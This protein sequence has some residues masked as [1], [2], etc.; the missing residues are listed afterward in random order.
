[1]AASDYVPIFFK[2]RLHLAGRPQMSTRPRLASMQF[3]SQQVSTWRHQFHL[4]L[5]PN[6]LPLPFSLN[7]NGALIRWRA[8]R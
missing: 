6:S 7:M 4:R 2:N 5:A 1:M 3:A 8:R